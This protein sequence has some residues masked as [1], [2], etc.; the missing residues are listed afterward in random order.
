MA[1][2]Q[3]VEAVEG[4]GKGRAVGTVAEHVDGAAADGEHA[5][6]LGDEQRAL[7]G[8]CREQGRAQP[9][10]AAPGDHDVIGC[11]FDHSSAPSTLRVAPDLP[12]AAVEQAVEAGA[13]A[14][15]EVALFEQQRLDPAHGEVAQGSRARGS[16]A[17][18][19]DV[20]VPLGI[21]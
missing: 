7:P 17:D 6:A 13:G 10:K 8:L 1:R 11:S 19:D 12:R 3:A 16:A 18:D 5:G 15:D 20:P 4:R 14:V 21:F 2:G 9:G